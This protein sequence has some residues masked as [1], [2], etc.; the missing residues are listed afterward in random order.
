MMGL[1]QS[2]NS[3]EKNIYL[4]VV[5]LISAADLDWQM[6]LFNRPA[7]NTEW[8][9]KNIYSSAGLCDFCGRFKI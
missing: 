8:R 2:E 4:S 7:A 3:A 1:Q 9:K 6:L 5:V